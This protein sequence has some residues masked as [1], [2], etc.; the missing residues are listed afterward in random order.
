M[1]G[2]ERDVTENLRR[3]IGDEYKNKKD[4]E[5]D[6]SN[7]PIRYEDMDAMQSSTYSAS[8]DVWKRGV[9]CWTPALFSFLPCTPC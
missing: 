8:S 4:L 1:Q 3:Y 5:V 6:T 2:K 9:A 7:W